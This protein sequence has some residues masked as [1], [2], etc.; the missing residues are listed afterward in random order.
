MVYEIVEKKA[1]YGIVGFIYLVAWLQLDGFFDVKEILLFLISQW[2]E[3]ENL[4]KEVQERDPVKYHEAWQRLCG[5]EWVTCHSQWI[6][7][8]F[9]MLL[10]F[11]YVFLV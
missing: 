4:E 7:H 11:Y 10:V 5:C 9:L 2:V 3:S 6:Y 8:I 1:F